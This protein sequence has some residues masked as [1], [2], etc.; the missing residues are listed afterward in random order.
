MLKAINTVHI[1]NYL[2]TSD[3]IM[4]KNLPKYAENYLNKDLL[5]SK[6]LNKI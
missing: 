5:I 3:E 1:L 2:K 6:N 4:I